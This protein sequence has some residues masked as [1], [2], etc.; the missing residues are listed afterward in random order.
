ME[1][2]LKINPLRSM[3]GDYGSLK[4]GIVAD[5]PDSVAGQLIK[6]GVAVPAEAAGTAATHPPAA[7]TGGR[8]GKG[9]P[10][11]SSPA[12]QASAKSTSGKPRAKRGS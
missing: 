4:R 12:A 1:V 7:P 10:S 2:N 9:K 6:R 5:V 8:T 3:V 11:S